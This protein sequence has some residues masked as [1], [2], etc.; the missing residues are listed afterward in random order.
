MTAKGASKAAVKAAFIINPK[1]ANS[2]AMRIWDQIRDLVPDLFPDGGT[3]FQTEYSGHAHILARDAVL[4]GYKLLVAIGGDGT[5]S[6]VVGG[7]LT[8][9]GL[10]Q[11]ASVAIIPSGTGGDFIRTFET[12]NRNPV[13]AL[14]QIL[15][16]VPIVIDAASVQTTELDGTPSKEKKY[17]VNV[18]SA[19]IGGAVCKAVDESSIAKI[20]GSLTY[21]IYTLL[22]NM[23]YKP[24]KVKCHYESEGE[25]KTIERSIYDLAIGNARCFGGGMKIAPYADVKDGKLDVTILHSLTFGPLLRKIE[26]GLRAGDVDK[27]A[28]EHVDM[29]KTTKITI[30]TV[31]PTDCAFIQLDGEYSGVLPAEFEIVPAC[32]KLIVP[33][34]SWVVSS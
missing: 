18:A 13:K 23:T 9:N 34:D 22:G 17:F 27:R 3:L 16:G 10:D 8:A 25:T 32:V 12:F 28:P 20:T 5:I 11:G 26:P 1:A 21:T 15:Q 30:Q 24:I 31:N 6:Q 2:K 29:L 19:G 4:T 33:R 7:Y 14:E